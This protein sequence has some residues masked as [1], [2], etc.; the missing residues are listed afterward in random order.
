[1]FRTLHAHS[2]HR[3]RPMPSFQR[4]DSC[5]LST[6]NAAI[7]AP[8]A[9]DPAVREVVFDPDKD[10][11]GIADAQRKR[12][13]ELEAKLAKYRGLYRFF[14]QDGMTDGRFVAEFERTYLVDKAQP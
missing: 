7:E 8:C 4:C 1:M 3:M 11:R 9:K 6:N 13:A 10:W 14:G 5:G 2:T 12:I